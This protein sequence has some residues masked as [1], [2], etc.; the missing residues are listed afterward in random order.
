MKAHRRRKGK[1]HTLQS[2]VEKFGI[3]HSPATY[4]LTRTPIP[5]GLEAVYFQSFSG[6]GCE[7]KSCPLPHNSKPGC[8]VVT[9]LIELLQYIN[10]CK[11]SFCTEWYKIHDI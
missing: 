4:P 3:L 8:L 11:A 2:G 5:F 6:H 1:L 7:D 9:S 10:I